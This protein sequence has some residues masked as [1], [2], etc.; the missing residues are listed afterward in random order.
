MRPSEPASTPG[1]L[2]FSSDCKVRALNHSSKLK[3]EEQRAETWEFSGV[4][5][6]HWLFPVLEIIQFLGFRVKRRKNLYCLHFT[7]V[8]FFIFGSHS[9]W[10]LQIFFWGKRLR[11][12]WIKP[13]GGA[14]H[15]LSI[16]PA[17]ELLPSIALKT[18]T[19][20]QKK[21][22]AHCI[23][24]IRRPMTCYILFQRS[25]FMY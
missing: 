12:R 14:K 8:R 15:F 2:Q 4:K 16:L 24:K 9:N 23:W 5:L 18:W 11:F 25:F 10:K 17:A 6:L 21:S 20:N 1:Q 7:S 3:R 22:P 13:L 19:I